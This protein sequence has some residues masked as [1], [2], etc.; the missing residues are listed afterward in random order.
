MNEPTNQYR[1]PHARFRCGLSNS[2]KSCKDGPIGSRCSQSIDGEDGC[3]PI[4][5]LRGWRRLVF[6]ASTLLS[7]LLVL[8]LLPSWQRHTAIAPGPLSHAHAQLLHASFNSGSEAIN[9]NDRCAACHPNTLSSEARALLTEVHSRSGVAPAVGLQSQL[10]LNCHLDTMPNGL[11]GTPHDLVGEDLAEL[12]N[13]VTSS[14]PKALA[15]MATECS[16]CHREHQGNSQMLSQITSERC[17][18][19][20]RTQFDSFAKGHPDFTLYPEASPRS[21][22]FDHGKHR[23]LHFAKKSTSFDC[24]ACHLSDDRTGVVGNIFRSVS[25]EHACASCHQEPLQTQSTDGVLVLQIP[26]LDR[27]VLRQGGV[28]LGPWPVAASQIMDGE[29]S[30]LWR[31]LIRQAPDGEVILNRLPPSGR[32]QDIDLENRD[33]LVNVGKL[34]EAIRHQLKKLA[35]E[36]QPGLRQI[37]EKSEGVPSLPSRDRWLNAFASGV[38]VD[39]FRTAHSRWFATNGED[40]PSSQGNPQQ[41]GGSNDL[42]IRQP[43]RRSPPVILFANDARTLENQGLVENQNEGAPSGDL[44]GGEDLLGEGDSLL[45]NSD[46]LLLDGDDLL[47]GG[48]SIL[49]QPTPLQTAPEKPLKGWEHMP[50][51][52]WMIDEARVALVYIPQP[53]GDRWLSRWIEWSLLQETQNIGTKT[54]VAG[55]GIVQQCLQCHSM[56][57]STFRQDSALD[58]SSIFLASSRRG[59]LNSNGDIDQ[60]WKI[61]QRPDSFRSITKFNHAPHLTIASLN[62]CQSCHVLDKVATPDSLSVA[63][64]G[65]EENGRVVHHEFRGMNKTLCATCHQ[66]NGAGDSCTQCHNYHVHSK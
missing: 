18:A 21:I 66:R 13:S 15:K 9:S 16:Q 10:C 53:H 11:A 56:N 52:G 5:T 48:E 35:S 19:C 57:E 28:E 14:P 27:N 3:V 22:S 26:S 62:D 46:S 47:S 41:V 44:L 54:G 6:I 31:E 38:P 58:P 59:R 39:L 51:G 20:H 65:W 7:I 64:H 36:G 2:G 29:L 33:Q 43:S 23:D 34:A 37:L 30:P 40:V 55:Q 63:S 50:Y 45:N 25:F 49:N 61:Q 24:K 1:T 17:Q 60:A 42:V 8:I 12:L 32:L 4:R